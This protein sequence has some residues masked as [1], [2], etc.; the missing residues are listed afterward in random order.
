MRSDGE[1]VFPRSD[2]RLQ[3]T[4]RITDGWL[5]GPPLLPS[6]LRYPGGKG[7]L[8][9]FFKL[10]LIENGLAGAD[11]TRSHMPAAQAWPSASFTTD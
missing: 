2:S 7:K 8:A 5:P 10:L 11:F 4:G 9:N 3:A 1:L 6:P